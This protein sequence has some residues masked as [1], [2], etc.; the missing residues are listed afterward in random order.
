M[1]TIEYSKFDEKT[2]SDLAYYSV[3]NEKT[4]EKKAIDEQILWSEEEIKSIN[5]IKISETFFEE[6]N[7]DYSKW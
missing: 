1:E 3:Q 7:E 4:E 6:D 2:Y 5:K